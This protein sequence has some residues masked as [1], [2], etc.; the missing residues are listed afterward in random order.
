VWKGPATGTTREIALMRV[1]AQVEELGME[2]MGRI[3]ADDVL[4]G[5][6]DDEQSRDG[7]G[8]VELA[9]NDQRHGKKCKTGGEASDESGSK[10]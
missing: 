3:N 10:K 2:Q 4:D 9:G 5:E 7:D 6:S 1:V 8:D